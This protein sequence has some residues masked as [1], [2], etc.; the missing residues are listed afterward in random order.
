MKKGQNET[1]VR[2]L[3][4]LQILQTSS[5]AEHPI[6]TQDSIRLLKERWGLDAYRIAVQHDIHA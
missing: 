5:D 1:R 3:W 4:M 6:S 2:T